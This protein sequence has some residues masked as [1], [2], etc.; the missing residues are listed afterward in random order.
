M[1]FQ[2]NNPA[3]RNNNGHPSNNGQDFEKAKAFININFPRRN[4]ASAQIGKIPLRMSQELEKQLLEFIEADE[5]EN[6]PKVVNKLTFTFHLVQS[7][8]GAALDL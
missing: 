4:G 5:E 3:A 7:G 2:F 8:E 6:F 1:A